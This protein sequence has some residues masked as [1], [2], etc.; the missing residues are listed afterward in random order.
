[1]DSK[2]KNQQKTE[3]RHIVTTLRRANRRFKFNPALEFKDSQLPHLPSD[4]WLIAHMKNAYRTDATFKTGVQNL[5]KTAGRIAIAP[6]LLCVGAV[7]SLAGLP[8]VGLLM[9]AG[10]AG[11]LALG[12]KPR[13]RFK[14]ARINFKTVTVPDFAR[15]TMASY[16]AY[17]GVK[18]TGKFSSDFAR[19]VKE[20]WRKRKQ[21]KPAENTAAPAEPDAATPVTN[22]Q[23]TKTAPKKKGKLKSAFG[24]IRN[25]LAKDPPSNDNQQ[26]QDKKPTPKSGPKPS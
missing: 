23:A 19:S 15:K 3:T 1:M 21:P 13:A 17:K 11:D 25:K 18:M 5:A 20:K 4:Q 2:A 26:D 14:A 8:M 9:M 12:S 10:A 6:A 7:V 22:P 16:A 24:K